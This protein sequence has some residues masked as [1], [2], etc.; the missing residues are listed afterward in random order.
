[1]PKNPTNLVKEQQ[2]YFK[3]ISGVNISGFM[4]FS[5]VLESKHN[6][7]TGIRTRLLRFCSPAL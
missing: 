2:W 5:R 1:M 4:P 7:A 3:P 6:S